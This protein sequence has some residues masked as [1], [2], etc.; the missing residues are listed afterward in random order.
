MIRQTLTIS[1]LVLLLAS[2]GSSIGSRK[3]AV[4]AQV[5][6]DLGGKASWPG[7]VLIC[8]CTAEKDKDCQCHF[9]TSPPCPRS[10]G[11][12]ELQ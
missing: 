8:D 6:C 9:N 12:E 4:F 3:T 10:G 1:L 7:G 5:S 11:D 2:I